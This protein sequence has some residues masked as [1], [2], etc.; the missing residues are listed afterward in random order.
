[1]R[2]MTARSIRALCARRS[3]SRLVAT[4][5]ASCAGNPSPIFAPEQKGAVN[6]RLFD[7]E[8]LA[9][10]CVVIATGARVA[11]LADLPKGAAFP[12]KGEALAIKRPA[13]GPN[14]VVRTSSAYLCPKADGRVVIG[15]TEVPGDWSLNADDARVEALKKGAA[16]AF[17]ALKDAVEVE[18]WAGLR[19]ATKDGAPIIGPA[20]ETQGVI[21]AL[22]HYRNGIL[23]AP[24]TADAIVRLIVE[25]RLDPSIAAFSAAR[26]NQLGVS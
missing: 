17:P 7:G 13:S 8:T 19:P 14:R 22:G 18:R 1:M 21:F 16:F 9:A 2:R 5:G 12:V 11:G 10:A 6:A 15:A 3:N 24:A 23:L 20:P 26:F 25:G 4:A